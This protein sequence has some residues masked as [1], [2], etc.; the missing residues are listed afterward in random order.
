MQRIFYLI[1]SVL[2]FMVFAVGAK[3]VLPLPAN[4]NSLYT[5]QKINNTVNFSVASDGINEMPGSV[6]MDFKKRIYEQ[7]NINAFLTR[8]SISTKYHIRPLKLDGAL[9]RISI[10]DTVLIEAN[11]NE[12]LDAAFTTFL[13][14]ISNHKGEK[15]LS[16][17][18]ITDNPLVHKRALKLNLTH[19]KIDVSVLKKQVELMQYLKL[20]QLVLVLSD[21]EKCLFPFNGYNMNDACYSREEL[22][23]LVAFAK[24]K[25]IAVIPE[26]QMPVVKW[27]VDMKPS[28]GLELSKDLSLP[29]LQNSATWTLFSGLIEDL[30]STFTDS[31]IVL[32]TINTDILKA[33][34]KTLNS[35]AS[36]GSWQK[37]ACKRLVSIAKAT[38]SV[39]VL[40]ENTYRPVDRECLIVRASSK[41][42]FEQMMSYK[43]PVY[44]GNAIVID[45][46]WDDKSV[47]DDELLAGKST[48]KNAIAAEIVLPAKWYKAVNLESRLWPAA[49]DGAQQLWSGAP[50]LSIMKYSRIKDVCSLE[51]EKLGSTHL[52]NQNAI[53][54]ELVGTENIIP[55]IILM[56]TLEPIGDAESELSYADAA[57]MAPY[58]ARSF[59]NALREFLIAG[60][61]EKNFI[62]VGDMLQ[63]WINNSLQLQ[64]FFNAR[65]ELKELK[66]LSIALTEIAKIGD[67]ALYYSVNAKTPKSRW[68]EE[69]KNKM[70]KYSKPVAGMKFAIVDGIKSLLQ[71]SEAHDVIEF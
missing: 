61:S 68:V 11:T 32:S 36:E 14:L 40:D 6:F 12:G 34:E 65:P 30:K 47:F 21:N 35:I 43:L 15:V 27:Y 38:N 4:E 64:A 71:F 16:K 67:Q 46:K 62:H 3:T 51:L 22:K 20:N 31:M 53:V 48:L 37:D 7:H 8:D 39:F 18:E 52:S 45:Q 24:T 10:N 5:H 59:N 60:K 9:Y 29:N 66:Q 41:A 58:G 26:I 50:N 49:I 23:S 25:S 33:Y 19:T 54:R 63:L 69:S 1:V 2:F 28:I 57:V 70:D 44:A 56:Q 55:L 17:T 42:T 13:Q